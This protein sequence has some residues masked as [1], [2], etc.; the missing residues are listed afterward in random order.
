MT[1]TWETDGYYK[2]HQN[3]DGFGYCNLSNKTFPNKVIIETDVLH[4]TYHNNQLR[5]GLYNPNS[6]NWGVIMNLI[7]YTYYAGDLEI[8]TGFAH[9]NQTSDPWS[10]ILKATGISIIGTWYTL[11]MIIDEQN[12]TVERLD[13]NKTVLNTLTASISSS[14][15]SNEV[16]LCMEHC[17][18][19]DDVSYVKNL[20]VKPYSV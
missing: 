2:L 18:F 11:R 19:Y 14:I 1:C 4:N 10:D 16:M 20:K 17:Y 3:E 13:S 6:L 9:T 12:I 7:R 5:I 15:L 8:R